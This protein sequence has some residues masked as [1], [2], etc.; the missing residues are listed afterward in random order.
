[1]FERKIGQ[2]KY[3][4]PYFFIKGKYAKLPILFIQKNIVNKKRVQRRLYDMK[5]QGEKTRGGA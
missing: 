3:S 2:S 4:K 1:M 5:K